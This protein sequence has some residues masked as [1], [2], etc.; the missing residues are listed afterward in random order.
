VVVRGLGDE[1]EYCNRRNWPIFLLR[2][3][4][5]S[6]MAVPYA[7]KER[8]YVILVLPAVMTSGTRHIFFKRDYISSL[9][10]KYISVSLCNAIPVSE[11]TT[12]MYVCDA[13]YAHIHRGSCNPGISTH[14]KI[15]WTNKS[16]KMY[17]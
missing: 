6:N 12:H 5:A 7:V 3:A 16:R 14:V 11:R 13:R 4:H 2:S 17:H 8:C 15:T 9:P 10:H 1:V